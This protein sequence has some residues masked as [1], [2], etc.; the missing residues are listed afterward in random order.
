MGRI[1][2]PNIKTLQPNEVFVFGSNENGLHNGGA[3]KFAL[4]NFGAIYGNSFGIQGQSFA[5]PTL[6]S[7]FNEL[8]IQK[9][10]SY[11][12]VFIEFTKNNTNL[13]FMVTEIGCGIAG[14]KVNDIAPLFIKTIELKNVYLPKTFLDFF[15][16]K[17]K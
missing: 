16:I 5:I 15:K 8:P 1:S 6:D 2:S 12:D 10:K 13:D 11:V 7:E 9:I 14:F 4:D 3:A 17:I